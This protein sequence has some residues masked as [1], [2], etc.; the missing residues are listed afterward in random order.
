MAS[1]TRA[2]PGKGG[3]NSRTQ[4]LPNRHALNTLTNGDPSARKM[5]NYAKATP[6]DLSGVATMATPGVSAVAPSSP[7]DDKSGW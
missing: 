4:F 7:T 3:K 6:L 5:G 1:P 2:G